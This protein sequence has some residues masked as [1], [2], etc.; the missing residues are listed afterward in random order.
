VPL[1]YFFKWQG[2]TQ[3]LPTGKGAESHNLRYPITGSILMYIWGE[4]PKAG[5]W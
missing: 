2:A 1:W 5:V 3:A 4:I